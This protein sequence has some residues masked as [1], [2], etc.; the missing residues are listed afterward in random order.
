MAKHSP[1]VLNLIERLAELPGIGKKTAERL[2]FFL[3]NCPEA[4]ALSLSDA[5]RA[6]REK[7]RLCEVC[8]NLCEES[9]CEICSDPRR[10]DEQLCVVETPKDLAIIESSVSYRGKYHVLGGHIAPLDNVGPEDLTI[11][12]LLARVHQGNVREV[13]FA[14]NP[15]AEGDT[16]ANYIAELLRPTGVSLSRLARGL[17]IGTEIE[18]A[19]RNNLSEAL[20]GRQA[21]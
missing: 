2:A 8:Y 20:R 17:P 4:D 14:T 9:P 11:D 19:A 10:T 13:I 1:T 18:F 16:T 15:T 12:S 6:V 21:F 7:I 5:I 3:L